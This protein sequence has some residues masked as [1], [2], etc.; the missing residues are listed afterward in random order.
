MSASCSQEGSCP[1][2]TLWGPCCLNPTSDTA[3][4]STLA[5][6]YKLEENGQLDATTANSIVSTVISY[7][8]TVATVQCEQAFTDAQVIDLECTNPKGPLVEKNPNCLECQKLAQ[9][10]VDSRNQ[11]EQE[12]KRRNPKYQVQTVSDD[13][14]AAYFGAK[15]DFSDGVCVYVCFQCVAENISQNIQMKIVEECA[16]N[17]GN[18]PFINAF[19][20]GMSLQAESELS[21][22]T[23]QL[24]STGLNIKNQDDIKRLSI[25]MA[26]TLEQ[27]TDITQLNALNQSALNIQETKIEPGSTSV[28]IQNSEQAITVSM[29]AS[30]ISRTY[31][32]TSV[33]NS[34]D[35]QVQQQVIEVE[36]S[37][38]DLLKKLET[39]VRTMDKLL[40]ST[41]GKIM[42]T[43]VALLLTVLIIFAAIFFFKPE[44]LFGGGTLRRI[45]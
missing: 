45:T 15:G 30:L 44:F 24:R 29:F 26:N 38:A 17:I 18:E 3:G 33:Q 35:Y 6:L 37:F 11:L 7:G 32:N 25:E 39:T 4:A 41:V 42:I 1:P 8:Y 5:R 22:Y 16:S 43:L 12:A 28:V 10:A 19:V 36:T 34:I 27:M 31:S 21:K 13:V 2:G 23:D 20:S 9:Q 14:K 40:I